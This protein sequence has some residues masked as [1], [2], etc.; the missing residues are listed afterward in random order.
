MLIYSDYQNQQETDAA[1]KKREAFSKENDYEVYNWNTC[2]RC[3]NFMVD[4]HHPEY[5]G[6]CKLM[7]EAGAYPGVLAE[8]VCDKFL[9]SKGLDINNEPVV[10]E[11]WPE[12]VRIK[13]CYGKKKENI[14]LESDLRTYAVKD[15][16]AIQLIRLFNIAPEKICEVITETVS[17]NPALK[18]A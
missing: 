16:I 17:R 9:S 7:A 1:H 5:G 14:L 2:Y 6:K 13:E 15:L 18:S 3:M 12:W 10:P 4:L 11:E 8:A